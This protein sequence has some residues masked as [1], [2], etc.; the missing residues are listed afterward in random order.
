VILNISQCLAGSVQQGRYATS[1][2]F[3]TIG[4]ISGGDLSFEAGLCK[5]MF[6]LANCAEGEELRTYLMTPLVGEM[7][8]V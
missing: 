5:L 1:S 6:G 2:A 4:V 7:D 8:V 3:E